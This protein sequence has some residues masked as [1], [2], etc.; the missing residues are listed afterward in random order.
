M[1][2]R[3]FALRSVAYD[4]TTG[5]P[6]FPLLFDRVRSWLEERRVVGVIHV[7]VEELRLVESLY[8]FQVVDRL[9]VRIAGVLEQSRSALLP[10]ESRIGI[11]GV[12]GERFAAF[13]PH[14]ADRESVDGRYLDDLATALGERLAR[15][16]AGAE[17][18]GLAPG[19]EFRLGR[20]LVSLDPFQRFERR[21]WAALDEA[22]AAPE[23]RRHRRASGLE[24]DLRRMIS[25]A[26]LRTV[27]QPV[28]ELASR[29][30]VGFEAFSRGP[31]DCTLDPPGALFALSGK[32]GLSVE[33]DH[34]C[35]EAALSACPPLDPGRKI[36]LNALPASFRT[37]G[38]DPAGWPPRLA[39]LAGSAATTVLEFSERAADANPDDFVETLCRWKEVGFGVAIDDMGTGFSG[40][41]ILERLRPDWLKLDV[42]LVRKIDESL[43]Q[44]EILR[45]L[46]RIAER[47]GASVIAEG[48][49]TEGEAGALVEAGARYGQGHLFAG[50]AERGRQ[51]HVV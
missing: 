24:D 16:F 35:R 3:D 8:G 18:A 34:A 49:E 48:I 10:E 2:R 39:R 5:L 43:I 42:S 46:V 37:L 4:R 28:V 7:E 29:E 14:R 30:V 50:P 33:L 41:G 44:Q 17:F 22:R 15:E 40:N 12:G 32:L 38:A 21:L 25:G 13:V 51:E 23:R 20:A 26:A 45:T 36:F 19:L 9:L 6:A 47:V 1:D 11:S 31:R 27:F